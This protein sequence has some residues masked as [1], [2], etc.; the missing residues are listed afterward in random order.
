MSINIRTGASKSFLIAM[1][2]R[3]MTAIS[4]FAAAQVEFNT[5]LSAALE[6]M[7]GD[8]AALSAKITELEGSLGRLSAEDQATLDELKVQAENLTA[9]AEAL[10]A[11]TPPV[12]PAPTE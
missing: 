9:R 12:V 2:K 10:D 8:I 5:R 1:E 11:L 4:D 3:L 7:S 6:G